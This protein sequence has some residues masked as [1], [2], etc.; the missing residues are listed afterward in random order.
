MNDQEFEAYLRGALREPAPAQ[1]PDDVRADEIARAVSIVVDELLW[2]EVDLADDGHDDGPRDDAIRDDGP[3]DDDLSVWDDVRG[4]GQSADDEFDDDLVDPLLAPQP[5]EDD[6]DLGIDRA[7]TEHGPLGDG[8]P[9][10]HDDHDP[11]PHHD[12]S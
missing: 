10:L 3:R 12:D 2:G 7:S 6:A 1:V 9:D 4:S 5:R 11:A 8:R